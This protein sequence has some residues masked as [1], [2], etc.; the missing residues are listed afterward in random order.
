MQDTLAHELAS[1]GAAPNLIDAI[2]DSGYWLRNWVDPFSGR[3]WTSVSDMMYGNKQFSSSF[4]LDDFLNYAQGKHTFP[5]LP[6]LTYYRVRNEQELKD[7]LS[8]PRRKHYIQEGSFTFRGQPSEYRFTRQIPSPL[9]SASDGSE[10][11]ILPGAYR[12]SGGRY[13]FSIPVEEIRSLQPWISS[14]EPESLGRFGRFA[15]DVMRTEQHYANQTRGLDLGFA[16]ETAIFFATHKYRT[17]ESGLAYFERVPKG[18]H[19]GVIYCFRFRDPPVNETQYLIREF[20]VF[21]THPPLRVLRQHC[22]LPLFMDDERNIAITDLDCAIELHPDFTSSVLRTPEY[23]FPSIKDDLFYAQLLKLKER[24]PKAMAS[25]VEYEW[26]RK[27][28]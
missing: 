25:V 3:T 10:L 8:D 15:Y 11:S 26:A 17:R 14:L 2:A 19:Q 23:M 12:Q 16:I 13:S 28:T 21:Q 18:A 6:S 27:A 22:G 7:L 1:R 5:Q 9:R 20:D 24:Y 4:A